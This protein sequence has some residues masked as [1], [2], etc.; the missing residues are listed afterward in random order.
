MDNEN[1]V[2]LNSNYYEQFTDTLI[3]NNYGTEV[4][5]EELICGISFK[6]T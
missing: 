6:I 4:R 5:Q 2:D 1:I 3:L